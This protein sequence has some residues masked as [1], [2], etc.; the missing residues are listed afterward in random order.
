MVM[1]DSFCYGRF[2]S[3]IICHC[4]SCS[5]FLFFKIIILTRVA[6]ATSK[7]GLH[8]VWSVLQNA[9]SILKVQQKF[10]PKYSN[11]FIKH[12]LW[13]ITRDL[14]IITSFHFTFLK[15]LKCHTWKSWNRSVCLA[16]RWATLPRTKLTRNMSK[17]HFTLRNR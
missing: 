3:Y 6:I 11:L 8:M 17:F 1:F 9:N 7:I 12:D 16:N 15:K 4:K 5:F 2:V 10:I 14:W 13:P